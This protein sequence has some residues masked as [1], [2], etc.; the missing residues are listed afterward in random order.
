[1]S[2]FSEGDKWISV[3]L[4]ASKVAKDLGLTDVGIKQLGDIDIRMRWSMLSTISLI[5]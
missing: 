4:D 1:M 5:H 2:L 3:V